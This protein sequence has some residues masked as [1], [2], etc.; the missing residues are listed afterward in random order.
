[1]NISA[2]QLNQI[3]TTVLAV[4]GVLS[5]L[6]PAARWLA[7]KTESKT[8]DATVEKIATFIHDALRFIPTL[9]FGAD[10]DTQKVIKEV[11]AVE[12]AEGEPVVVAKGPEVHKV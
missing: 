4:L 1:M 5:A 11:K 8:D 2:D 10:L 6:I 12:K 7:S 9:R 3:S